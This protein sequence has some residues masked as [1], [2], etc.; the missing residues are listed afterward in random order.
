MKNILFLML[1]FINVAHAQQNLNLANRYFAS[2]YYSEAIPLYEEVAAEKQSLE[3]VRNLADSYYFTNN[4]KNA[5]RW[6]A[7]LKGKFPNELK[8]ESF[9]RYIHTL[10]ATGNYEMAYQELRKNVQ[11]STALAEVEKQIAGLE[12]LSAA[13]SRF[14]IRHLPFNTD[15]SEFGA[16]EY[17]D[18]LIFSG[19]GAPKSSSKIY[20]W[21]N[22]KYLGLQAV[23]LANLA[24][25]DLPAKNFASEIDTELHEGS[26]VFT[27][28][29]KQ[30][31]FTRNNYKSGKRSSDKDNTSH[32]QIYRAERVSGK[33]GN[34]V[35]MPFNSDNY[36]TEHPALS[37][38]EK[39]LFF[40]S[41]MPGSIGSFDIYAVAVNNGSFGIPMNLGTGI[42]TIYKE[43]F[44]F[45]SADNRLYFAS[46]GHFGYGALDIF[47]SQMKDGSFSTPKNL[48]PEVNSGYDDFA[49]TIN[50]STRKG[51]FSSNRST[52]KGSDDIYEL[53]EK[54]PFKEQEEEIVTQTP[55]QQFKIEAIMANESDVVED[56]G[57]LII[58]TEP[59]YFDLDLWYIRKES[60]TIL[61][62][63]IYLMNK[64]PKIVVEIGSHTDVR[65]NDAYNLELSSKRAASTRAY[66]IENGIPEERISSKGYGETVPVI[67]C[68]PESACSEE[69]HELNR[70][71]EFVITKF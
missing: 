3:V 9:F 55:E 39:T 23:A 50:T 6:Y 30:I 63:V 52:G 7:V 19:S 18:S 11:G 45:V 58:K 24:E 67:R 65:A 1:V 12:R 69:Q 4:F 17:N 59:I 20:R 21:N 34:V 27:N 43:Q 31:Y 26:A 41:D 53:V 56:N 47:F 66:F 68:V 49:F 29:G 15:Y 44:P 2:T 14:T 71:S 42:N 10:K 38:D 25:V 64:Y 8:E 28:D 48:G 13:G 60:K 70:R 16:V 54:I 5:Q 40:S 57:R 32:L 22:E 61:N 62:R 35:P 33:W 36:S 51:Y 46:D 37:A